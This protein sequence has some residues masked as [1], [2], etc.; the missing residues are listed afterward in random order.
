METPTNDNRVTGVVD[1]D[2]HYYEPDDAFVRH[3]DP[4]FAERA[5]SIRRATDTDGRPYF[6]QQPLYY[7]ERTPVDRMG[8]P[9]SWRH[10]KDGR[11]Q[12]LPED[13][14]LT[15]GQIP[16]LFRQDARM[17]WMDEVGVEACV[18]WPSLALGIE[19]QMRDDPAACAANFS[20]FNRWLEEDWGFD[21]G[22][23]IFGAPWL[24]LIDLDTA[25][26]ELDSLIARGAR[27]IAVL[28]APVNGRSLGDPY[29]DPIWARCAEAGVPVG[30]HGAES[31]YNQLFSTQWGEAGRPAAHQQ[32]P[33]QRA[34]FFERAIMDTLAAFV[35][36]NVFGRHP[37]L[38]VM[39]IE[40]GSAWVPYLLRVMDKAIKSGMYGP[41]LGG[42]V[43]ERPSDIFRRHISVAPN[44]DDDIR[45]LVDLIG[46]D[47]VLLGSDYPHPEGHEDPLHFLDGSGLTPEEVGLIAHDNTAELL[48]LQE[49]SAAGG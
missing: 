25:I 35:L 9:G 22:E 12:P 6:G 26:V 24:T 20:S 49:A 28:F 37:G 41:S 27:A 29:F 13:D 30:F 1:A 39:S 34:A 17:A 8:R 10:D 40:N 31:G 48:R 4:A 23:R 5:L 43:T 42:Q 45:G 14:L 36:H 21:F 44:D 7:L 32:S 47:R 3:L 18:L 16:H 38:Q 19:V 2:N 15:P 46:A 11:Y 33:F